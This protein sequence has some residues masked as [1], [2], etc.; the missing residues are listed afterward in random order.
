MMKKLLL[1]L[2]V[3][4]LSGCDLTPAA[5]DA[6]VC[7]ETQEIINGVC[8][9]IIPV[10]GTDE[11][12]VGNECEP[13]PLSC[14]PGYSPVDGECV[15]D[16]IICEVDQ[17]LINDE[18]VDLVPDCPVGKE[19]YNGVCV[20]IEDIPNG[21]DYT[22]PDVD[23][24]LGRDLVT[25]D[26]SLIGNIGE[27]Q[28][29]WC[30]EFNYTGLPNNE[31]W[32]YDVGGH[33][34]GNGEAQYYTNAD[35][36]NVYVENG[37]MTITAI[38]EAYGSNNYTST[39]LVSRD[40]G[41]WLYGKIQVR[42]ILPGGKGMWPA[43][44]MLPTDW[45][46]GGWPDSGEIDIMEYVGYDP[47]RVHS[48]IHTGAYNHSLGTQVGVSKLI[49]DP[50]EIFHVYEIEW[51]P[52]VI[53]AMIDGIEFAT[54]E[55]DPYESFNIDNYMAWPFDQRFHLLL[56]VA[57]GGAWGG[58]MG[59]DDSIFPQEFIIDYVRV[60][61]KDYAGMDAETPSTVSG[62]ETL[63]SL[64]TSAYV[65]WDKAVDDVMVKEY[66]LYLDGSLYEITSLNGYLINSLSPAT[67]YELKVIAVDFAGNKSLDAIY[68]FS[69]QSPS[70]TDDRVE[71]ELYSDMSG[72][73]TQSTTD[74]GGGLNVGWT[75]TGDFMEYDVIATSSR[76]YSIDFRVASEPGAAFDLYIDNVKVD[77]ITVPAT[78][79]WQSWITVTSNEF[80]LTTGIH[81][82]KIVMVGSGVNFNYFEFN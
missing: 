71:S 33:G 82:I 46:Y 61:Q 68:S 73:Q 66:E 19:L 36:D 54:F 65:K 3:V 76:N 53:R 64:Q 15:K 79:G 17:E 24:Y 45:S 42:A 23:P 72:V 70:T 81:S 1:I 21:P 47:N 9:D 27:W 18:C 22:Y 5:D 6:P 8:E 39:R 4:I 74:I 10:C 38:K 32:N 13:K 20:L 16:D 55:Y 2:S 78:G 67:T 7:L 25:D 63:S 52:G 48:T 56:N 80:A 37:F 12:L 43:A 29:V 62:F 35:E 49:Q 77:T 30:D 58:A 51:E 28:P 59:I 31:L 41:D 69:T 44:W 14:V 57:V 75:D 11:I 26:C 40:K 34:W 50:E 60:F